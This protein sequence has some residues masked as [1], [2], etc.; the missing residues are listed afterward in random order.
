MAKNEAIRPSAVPDG[1]IMNE[2]KVDDVLLFFSHIAI[3]LL[4]V[5]LNCKVLFSRSAYLLLRSIR[6]VCFPMCTTSCLILLC[7]CNV[8]TGWKREGSF[9]KVHIDEYRYKYWDQ[10]GYPTLNPI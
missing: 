5:Q 10:Y 2:K 7:L 1:L 6:F 4:F 9:L 3:L 8:E